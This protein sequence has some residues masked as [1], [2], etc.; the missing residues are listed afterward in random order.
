[1]SEP[2]GDE[3]GSPEMRAA[4]IA[5][6][7]QSRHSRFVSTM[8]FALPL[9]ALALLATVLVY[10]GVFD[11][12]DKLAISFHE[13]STL[14]NDLRMVSPRVTGLDK[15]GRPYLLTADTATQEQGKPSH[16]TLDN[17]QADLKLPNDV[18]WVSL[19]ATGGLLDTETQTIVLHQKIDIYASTGYEFHG[20]EATVDFRNGTVASDA[21]VQGHGPL[22]TLRADSMTADNGDETIHFKGHV[23]V[24]LYGKH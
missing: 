15:S 8:K 11:A 10:S 20:T 13:I 12:R 14:N 23:K 1:M 5:E 21:P 17:V 22:G 9:G 24:R 6:W 16:V 2:L 4:P 3:P 7:Q 19:M 18:D